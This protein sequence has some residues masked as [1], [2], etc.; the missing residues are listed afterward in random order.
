MYLR[1]INQVREVE[2]A[3]SYNWDIK[4]FN[5][6]QGKPVNPLPTPFDQWFPAIDVEED[7]ADL[8]SY[9]FTRYMNDYKVP[10]KTNPKE[11]RITFYDDHNHKLSAWLDTWIN[12]EILNE[13]N[14]ISTLE[15]SVKFI[16]LA[17]TT[18]SK[19]DDLGGISD[20]A[21]TNLSAFNTASGKNTPNTPSIA[22]NK[23]YTYLC[24]YWVYP[25]GKLT[26]VGNSDSGLVQYSQT[27]VI[28]GVV[29]RQ[30]IEVTNKGNT[31]G[32]MEYFDEASKVARMALAGGA[33][34]ALSYGAERLRGQGFNF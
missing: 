9:T 24:S 34:A 1:N 28:C 30:Y 6:Q 10:Y 26:F 18:I 8:E 12:K 21:R 31:I 14:F 17:R 27:F 7:I 2:F 3:K 20:S 11:V 19:R 32:A 22:R 25:E 16:Q 23:N 5:S 29:D 4:L 33:S 15:D 13:G